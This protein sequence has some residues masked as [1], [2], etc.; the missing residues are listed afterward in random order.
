[1]RDYKPGEA[2]PQEEWEQI[3]R[4]L[5]QAREEFTKAERELTRICM[6][7]RLART[8]YNQISY[9]TP[10]V[11][12]KKGEDVIVSPGWNTPMDK[13]KADVIN[14]ELRKAGKDLA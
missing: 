11:I 3:E 2:I 13:E 12:K 8:R 14:E 10:S 7:Y 4:T 5:N 9:S 6:E 1:M